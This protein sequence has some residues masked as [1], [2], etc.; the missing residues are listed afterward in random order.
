MSH[1]GTKSPNHDHAVNLLQM[2]P[3]CLLRLDFFSL[4]SMA[5]SFPNKRETYITKAL[6]P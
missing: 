1:I 3:E 6:M 4:G 2:N 5:T